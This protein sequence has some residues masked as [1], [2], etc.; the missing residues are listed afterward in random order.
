MQFTMKINGVDFT[1]Y[2]R[3]NGVRFEEITRASRAVTVLNGTSY[4]AEITKLRAPVDLLE[5]RDGVWDRL[6]AALQTRPAEVEF[7]RADGTTS[8]KEFY[9]MG[10]REP[11]RSVKGGNT[12]YRNVSFTLEEK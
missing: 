1:P 9:V 5:M 8:V 4:R 6:R 2:L 3:A 7:T 10:L 11:V 12:Y